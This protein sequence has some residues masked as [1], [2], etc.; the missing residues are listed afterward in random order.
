LVSGR[1]SEREDMQ[2]QGGWRAYLWAA[3]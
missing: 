3:I 1:N 2:I